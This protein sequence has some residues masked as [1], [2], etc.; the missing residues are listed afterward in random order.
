[1]TCVLAA[2]VLALVLSVRPRPQEPDRS[3]E[4]AKDELEAARLERR[5]YGHCDGIGECTSVDVR[6]L[7]TGV[8]C[9][10]CG[11]PKA[12]RSWSVA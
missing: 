2:A 5:R 8:Y 10:D 3:R 9:D 1:M 7:R 11:R 12:R 6:V 4:R